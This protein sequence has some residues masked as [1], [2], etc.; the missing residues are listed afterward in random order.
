MQGVHDELRSGR[1]RTYDDEKVAELINRALQKKPPHA[2]AW[3]VRSM[4]E[5]EG[6]SHSTVHRWFK[7]HNLKP[8]QPKTVKPN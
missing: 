1:P 4:A 6:V 5:A 2:N 3:I 7:R 8:Q